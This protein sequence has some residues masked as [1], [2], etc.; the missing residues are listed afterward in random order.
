MEVFKQFRFYLGQ[1]GLTAQMTWDQ[2]MVN[3]LYVFRDYAPVTNV[4]ALVKLPLLLYPPQEHDIASK[5]ASR[6]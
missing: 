3:L 1:T 6:L 5:E 4:I 2:R